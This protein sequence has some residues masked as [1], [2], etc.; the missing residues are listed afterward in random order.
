MRGMIWNANYVLE[1]ALHPNTKDVP[2][3]L[4]EK[5]HGIVLLA[6]VK[7]GFLVTGHAG[8]GIMMAKD[9]ETGEWSPPVAIYSAGYSF[10]PLLGKKDDNLLIFIMDE[11]S[12]KDFAVRPQTRIGVTAALTL[13]KHGGEV[14]RGMDLPKKGT[15]TK[16]FTHGVFTGASIE[17]GTLETARDR[18]NAAYYGKKVKPSQVLFEKNSV[19]LP[20]ESLVPDIHKKLGLLARGETW[21]PDDVDKSKSGHFYLLA[22]Q[23]EEEEKKKAKHAGATEKQHAAE[24]EVKQEVALPA[25][26]PEELQVEEETEEA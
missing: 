22:K 2:K 25:N 14:N 1:E 19:T 5:C 18:Q 20:E 24:Q 15:I 13:G 16:V 11:E 7:A 10:G 21:V 12:M 9:I 17:M 4:F 8:S 6:M 3:E 26:N 23:A